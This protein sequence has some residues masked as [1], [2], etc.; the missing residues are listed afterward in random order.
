MISEIA[1]DI[2]I[3]GQAKCP[4]EVAE[5]IRTLRP[6]VVLL[7][8]QMVR[9]NGLEVL[10]D[11]KGNTPA[12]VVIIFTDYPFPQY[13]QRCLEDGAEFFFDKSSE[14]DRL[15]ETIEHLNREVRLRAPNSAAGIREMKQEQP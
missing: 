4:C 2:E 5:S 3:V 13:R 8:P 6:D 7:D 11:I 12:P 14:L 10:R 9:G 15:R 1:P